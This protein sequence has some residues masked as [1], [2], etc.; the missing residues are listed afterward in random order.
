MKNNAPNDTKTDDRYH[1]GNLRSAL[2]AAAELEL[3][4]NGAE[5]FSLRACA[6]RANV[7]HAAP[8]HHFG[9]AAGLLDALAALG[10][11]RLTETM[12]VEMNLAEKTAGAQLAASGLGYVRYA[13]E[14]PHLF[15]LMSASQLRPN[16]APELIQNA[17]AAFNILLNVVANRTGIPPLK[18]PNGWI[19]VA[20]SWAAVHGYAHLLISK[21]LV[22]L[23]SAE[24]EGHRDA[25][26][27]IAL[28]AVPEGNGIV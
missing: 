27:K 19:D 25:I 8:A 7:S 5:H 13:V 26:K 11:A 22:M 3:A 14:N 21:K 1:H 18:T 17:E 4:E 24:L 12:L 16:A 15:K 2:I 9:D 23:N 20:A 6:R 28:R 10:F